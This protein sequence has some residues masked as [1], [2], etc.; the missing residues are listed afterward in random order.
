MFMNGLYN[1]VWIST[2]EGEDDK[3]PD[4]KKPEPK[5]LTQEQ[6]DAAMAKEKRAWQQGN[7]K[8]ADEFEALKARASLTEDERT[9]LDERVK[10]L[11]EQLLTKDELNARNVKKIEEEKKKLSEDL[12]KDTQKWKNL[13]TTTSIDNEI[14]SSATKNKAVSP[15]QI[16]AILKPLAELTEKVDSEGKPIGGYETR[17]KF[18]DGDKVLNLSVD[19]A[20]KR[21]SEEEDFLNLFQADG[22]G[23]TGR[24]APD[25]KKS[26]SGEIDWVD[27]A[28]NDPK[29]Y[30]ELRAAG[31]KPY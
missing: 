25:T 6:F 8:M 27:L 3:K 5:L 23:G 13:Y 30:Q 26:N 22:T 1:K 21:M 16:I 29:K 15:K 17:I 28:K 24:K 20:V 7:S 10:S 2:F 18:P 12:T 11:N 31:K 14:I 19:D 9:Q 4:D